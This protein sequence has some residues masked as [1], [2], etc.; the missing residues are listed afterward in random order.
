MN[1]TTIMDRLLIAFLVIQPIL[2]FYMLYTN[3]AIQIFS[4]SIPTIIRLLFVFVALIYVIYKSKYNKKYFWI[5][6]YL[7]LIIIYLILHL[8]NALN[9]NEKIGGNFKFSYSTELF[10]FIRL[11]IP[12]LLVYITYNLNI[13]ENKF[14]RAILIV[15]LIFSLEIVGTNI[16]GVSLTSYG[17]N[18]KIDGTF[19]S[20]FTDNAFSFEQ[21]AS[22][23]FFYMANQISAVLMLLLPINIYFAIES[24]ERKFKISSVIMAISMMML[25]TR[26]AAYGWLLMFIT[27][28]IL[29]FL[30]KL[31]NREKI[32]IN[33]YNCVSYILSFIILIIIFANSPLI[34]KRDSFQLYSEIEE[35]G[36]NENIKEELKSIDESNDEET[37]AFIEDYS[38]KYSIPEIYVKKLY[39]YNKDS[40]FWIN[41]IK[42]PYSERGGNR[43]LQELI[44]KRVY[45]LND[46]KYDKYFG[47]G[48][49][50]FRNAQVYI[51]KDFEVHFF[52]MGI[53]GIILFFLPYIIIPTLY[54]FKAIK[55]KKINSFIATLCLTVYAVIGCSYF[56][57][58]CLDELLIT[59]YLGVIC[60]LI[61]KEMAKKDKIS[62]FA[63]KEYDSA[64]PFISVIVPVY[65]V[66]NY[67][68]K[69]LNSL[70]NQT[71]KNIEIIII[72]DGSTDNSKNIID[73]YTQKYKNIRSKTIKNKGVSHARN[74]GV[75]LSKGE[76]VAFVDSDDYVNENMYEKMYIKAKTND[77]DVISTNVN[78][79]YKNNTK[80]IN[81]VFKQDI[82]NNEIMKKRFLIDSYA[83]VWNKIYK[84]SLIKCVKFN[85]HSNYCEDVQYLYEVLPLANSIGFVDDYNY[86]YV[87]RKNSLITTY[88]E[89]VYQVINNFNF[90]NKLYV[91]DKRYKGY[92]EELEYSYVRYLYA[93]FVKRLSKC[94]NKITYYDGIQKVIK[95]VE[96]NYPNYRQ[97]KYLKRKKIKSVYLRLFN[98]RIAKLIYIFNKIMNNKTLKKVLLI[99]IFT[100]FAITGALFIYFNKII[101]QKV[102]ILTY[103]NIVSDEEYKNNQD[104]FTTSESMFKKQ[105]NF[106][107]KRG[108]KTLSLDEYYCWKMGKCKIPRRS[109]LITFDDGYYSVYKYA[110]PI[111]KRNNQKGVS[112]VLYGNV[113]EQQKSGKKQNSESYLS[114]DDIRKSKK[115]YSGLEYASHSM[116]LHNSEMHKSRTKD[117]I[118]ADIKNVKEYNNTKYYAYPNGFNNKQYRN[119]L[120]ENDFKLA[121]CFGPY[122]NSSKSD[123]NYCVSRIAAGNA[124]P[125]F[126]FVI[127]MYFIY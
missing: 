62:D 17:G 90:L 124:L 36:L 6:G 15:S 73:K 118:V 125:Y 85:E 94:A 9:F 69:C 16:L 8:T 110:L 47:M 92:M 2:D 58:H 109:V 45:S 64:S 120:K 76:Y 38:I 43:N 96:S 63:S 108:Y 14:R 28:P 103:H 78:L 13:T 32:R 24:N 19:F 50:R 93:S 101:E 46:N 30:I 68:E 107:K 126:K 3:Q 34:L 77:F 33:I 10:Y 26:I 121:F 1:K 116:N 88:D 12:I 86:N 25:G 105:L 51:E 106:L 18:N 60:G 112:F 48:Y 75:E 65:N 79:I 54:V 114:L 42:M 31:F 81:A 95:E 55:N 40:E 127:K 119:I 71:L 100:G 4:F 99:L 97:N 23:G 89:K 56:S 122:K 21:L 35:Q 111:L 67:L 41:T 59:I 87:Q 11:F 39:P 53:L 52:T 61:F 66:E 82:L 70:I 44:T 27:V 74:L 84:K 37:Q 104:F 72:N 123:D 5:F 98:K 49:S 113:L 117:E 29:Y 91:N 22:K 20:W 115:I 80:K 83:V 102:P 57:G 7:I